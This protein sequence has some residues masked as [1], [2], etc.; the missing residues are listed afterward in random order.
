VTEDETTFLIGAVLYLAALYFLV[1]AKRWW[2]KKERG[3]YI[4]GVL[5]AAAYV[6]GV[7]LK[8][9]KLLY[10]EVLTPTGH[11]LSDP[12][13]WWHAL[14]ILI[15]VVTVIIIIVLVKRWWRENVPKK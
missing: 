8:G 5:V 7:T 12:S 15:F 9:V 14:G 11:F 4:V 10:R 2:P 13:T 1:N 3:W 6:A